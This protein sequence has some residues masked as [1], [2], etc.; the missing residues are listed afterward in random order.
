MNY[1]WV[2]TKQQAIKAKIYIEERIRRAKSRTKWLLFT[3]PDME[4][5]LERLNFIIATYESEEAQR[6]GKG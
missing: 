1:N 6:N 3:L 2:K 4:K 5:A